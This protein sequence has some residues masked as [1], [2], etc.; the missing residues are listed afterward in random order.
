MTIVRKIKTIS[1]GHY[2]PAPFDRFAAEN[3]HPGSE[4]RIRISS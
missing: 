1:H 3:Q 4:S 2:Y